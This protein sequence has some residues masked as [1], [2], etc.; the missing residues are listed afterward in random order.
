MASAAATKPDPTI[1]RRR[2]VARIRI[3]RFNID[4]GRRVITSLID[5]PSIVNRAAAQ[6]QYSGG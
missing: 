4:R 3:S 2:N 6:E 5:R 1:D